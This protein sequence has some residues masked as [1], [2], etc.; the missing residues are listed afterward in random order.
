MHGAMA[1][2]LARSQWAASAH[3]GER[4]EQPMIC[5]RSETIGTPW[6]SRDRQ[7]EVDIAARWWHGI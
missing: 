3:P 1:L 7:I 2:Y 5:T 6:S 4:R